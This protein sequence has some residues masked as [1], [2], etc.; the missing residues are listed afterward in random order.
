[1]FDPYMKIIDP[2]PFFDSFITRIHFG[3]LA[4]IFDRLPY[5]LLT[6]MQ[7]Q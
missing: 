5:E 2:G 1:M 3:M 7:V 6:D 4:M